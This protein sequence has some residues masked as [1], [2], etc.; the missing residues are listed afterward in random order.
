MGN[1]WTIYKREMKSYFTSPIAYIFICAFLVIMGIWFF[2][3]R[4]PPS[5]YS[6]VC[7]RCGSL[8]EQNAV[9]R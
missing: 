5:L 9:H 7:T 2:F 8:L 6:W 3:F 4:S 1:T